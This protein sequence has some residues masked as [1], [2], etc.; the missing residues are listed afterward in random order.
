ME[1]RVTSVW[2][3]RTTGWIKRKYPNY[4]HYFFSPECVP[5]GSLWL[6]LV[7]PE[8]CNS[9]L[10]LWHYGVEEGNFGAKKIKPNCQCL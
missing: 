3:H 5:G 2:D 7:G 4:I 10:Q 1:L 8:E 6:A 9:V